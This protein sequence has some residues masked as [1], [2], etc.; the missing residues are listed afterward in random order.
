[1]FRTALTALAVSILAAALPVR[2]QEIAPGLDRDTLRSEIRAYLLENPEVIYEAIQILDQRRQLAQAAAELDLVHANADA[3]RHDGYSHVAGNPDGALTIVE[4]FDYRCTY[5]KRAQADVLTLMRTNPDI[6]FVMK[7]FPILGPDSVLAS[8]AAV[9]GLR[10]GGEK[11][12]RFHNT[13]M[14]FGGPLS[15][16][17]V[18][19]LAERAGLDVAKMRAD[20]ELPE[21]EQE[22]RK[23]HALAELLQV[24]G[25]PTFVIGDKI[26]RGFLPL[27]EMTKVVELARNVQN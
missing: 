12:E 27:D 20:M 24:S 3:L 6:R 14:A 2:A 8:R 21:V 7:E 25:T 11:Y 15:D 13:L 23:N 4:F 5:C 22:I 16:A 18:D 1:M 9:A 17:V 10:Q 19:K 26:V